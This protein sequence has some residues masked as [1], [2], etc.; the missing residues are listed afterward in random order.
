[1]FY[2]VVDIETTGGFASGS[3]ITEIAILIHDGNAVI[4]HYETLI[5]PQKPIP[6]SIQVLTGINDQMVEDAPLFSEVAAKIHQLLSGCVFIAHNVN[7]D[8]SFVKHH[9]SLAGFSFDAPRLCTVRM[10]RQIKPGL[11]SYSLGKLCDALGI[12]IENRHRA[13]GDAQATAIL[14]S[15]LL[16]WDLEGHIPAMLKRNSKD[17]HLP[18]NLASE[19]F[20]KLPSCPGVYYFK[21]KL[22]KEIYVGKALN[23]KKRVAS[24]FTGHSQGP[25]RQHFLRDIY[26]VDFEPCG[27]ELM[28][29]LLE[30]VEIKKLWPKYNRAMKRPEPRFALYAYEDSE[31]FTRLALGKYSKT[32]QA[33]QFFDKEADGI[34]MLRKLVIDYKLSAQRC[35]YGRYPLFA[36]GSDQV[37]LLSN[38]WQALSYQNY[39]DLVIEALD[40]YNSNLAS[41][42]IL[43]QG[44]VPGEQSCIYVKKGRLTRM[45]YIQDCSDLTDIS[46]VLETLPLYNANHY[47]NQLVVRYAEAHP[48]RVR[49]IIGI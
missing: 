37:L 8:Y 24:H 3:G 16:S 48:G 34:R 29:F 35:S 10:S 19:D 45:G 9:L 21:D 40:H 38:S 2:A 12:K 28:A 1:M 23:L 47:M 42:V 33:I 49:L 22:G 15:R 32:Q 14:F 5:N 7:F 27:T 31:G 43:D 17:Q 20:L 13:G 30:A 6:L 18:P 41:F 11:K 46:E 44:R 25:Q 39:N 4:E 26:S 36:E